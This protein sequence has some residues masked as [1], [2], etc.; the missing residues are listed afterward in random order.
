M[1]I[2][3]P[4]PP[5]KGQPAN[6]TRQRASGLLDWFAALFRTPTPAY[7]PARQIPAS[8]EAKEAEA[9]EAADKAEESAQL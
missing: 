3:T 1:F 8:E 2:K 4:T 6:G 5:Y 9:T 7:K